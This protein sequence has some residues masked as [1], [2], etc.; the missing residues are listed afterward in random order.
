MFRLVDRF[1][2]W[3]YPA[4]RNPAS[5]RAAIDRAYWEYKARRPITRAERGSDIE[6]YFIG[7]RDRAPG[8]LLPQNFHS[9]QTG[10]CTAA[11]DLMRAPGLKNSSGKFYQKIASTIFESDVSFA[12]LESTIGTPGGRKGSIYLHITQQEFDVLTGHKGKQYTVLSTANNHVLDGGKEGFAQLHQQLDAEGFTYVGTNTSRE[13]ASRGKVVEAGGLKIGFVAATFGVNGQLFP[14][15]KDYAVNLIPIHARHMRG[16]SKGRVDTSQLTEQ[17]SNCRDQGCDFVILSLHWGFEF[18]FFPRAYQIEMAQDLVEQGADAILG[19]HAHNIQPFEL[20]RSR[21]DPQRIAPIFYGLGNLSS[22]STAAYRSL[23]L[24]VA[25]NLTRGKAGVDRKT[26]VTEV[27]ITPVL[28]MQHEENA[29]PFIQ[30][31]RLGDAINKPQK[32]DQA[33]FV[34]DATRY[35]D[36]ILGEH[37]RN[38][39]TVRYS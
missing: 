3:Q 21:R 18:E 29:A 14:D 6:N 37:W 15:G 26:L 25:L 8:L 11:G 17:M 34:E 13:A 19:H 31:D 22:W 10:R 36:L 12:N 32:E 1:G 35:A 5:P 27:E 20:Y 2:Y 9:D 33:K 23:S 24:I 28:Q 7:Q 16:A 39:G 4:N 38:D 30:L